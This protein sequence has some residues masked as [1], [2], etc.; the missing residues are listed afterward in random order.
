MPLGVIEI[1]TTAICKISE[2]DLESRIVPQAALPPR[3]P[4]LSQVV[5]LMSLP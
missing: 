2:P 1:A 4:L 5:E 3:I